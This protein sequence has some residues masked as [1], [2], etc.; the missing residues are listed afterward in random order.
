MS[1]VR[2]FLHKRAYIEINAILAIFFYLILLIISSKIKVHFCPVPFT[3]QT[4]A[5]IFLARNLDTKQSFLTIG[6]YIL[7]GCIGLPIFN[8]NISN[9]GLPI[10]TGGYLI[11]MFCAPLVSFYM[12]K[13]SKIST[14]WQEFLTYY[15][16]TIVIFACGISWLAISIGWRKAFIGGFL[17]FI[18]SEFLIKYLIFVGLQ[19]FM[20]RKIN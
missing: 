2:F 1:F 15:L 7:L 6:I 14:F 4:L 19:K 20:R 16:N 17:P 12:Q 5:A 18:F 13:F 3:F 10:L 9:F 8:E 11:G